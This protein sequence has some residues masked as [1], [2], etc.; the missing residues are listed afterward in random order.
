MASGEWPFIR[1]DKSVAHGSPVARAWEGE[2]VSE[3][4]A[5]DEIFGTALGPLSLEA[6]RY[7]DSVLALARRP[8]PRSTR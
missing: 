7:G 6:R 2:L 5:L 1:K 4:A 3:V 8:A